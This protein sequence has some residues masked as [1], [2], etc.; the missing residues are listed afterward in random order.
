MASKVI[1]YLREGH[2]Y[3]ENGRMQEIEQAFLSRFNN[4]ATGSCQGKL[5]YS[6]G[7]G[8]MIAFEV[9]DA[10]KEKTLQYIR[11]LFHNGIV[12]FLAGQNPTRVR[13]LLPTCLTEEHIEE[14]FQIIKKT[15]H[16]VIT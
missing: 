16:E 3:G 11:A 6:G 5:G 4:L 14:I 1:R 10:S 7:V 12:A 15:A 13:F 8:T 9:G 2:F